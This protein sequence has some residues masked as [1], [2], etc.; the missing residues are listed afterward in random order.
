MP[1]KQELELKL[2]S[3]D[4]YSNGEEFKKTESDYK[5]TL[6]KLEAAN[7]EYEKVFEK[8]MELDDDMIAR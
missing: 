1:E 7:R 4:T 5:L 6:E 3:P 8:M 2:A